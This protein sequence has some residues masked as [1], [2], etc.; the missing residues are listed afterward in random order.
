MTEHFSFLYTQLNFF[1]EQ[2]PLVYILLINQKVLQRR[3][4]IH[5]QVQ[6]YL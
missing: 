4:P 3:N 6:P 2:R 1:G 5:Q